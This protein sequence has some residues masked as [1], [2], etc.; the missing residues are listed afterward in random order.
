MSKNN[1]YHESGVDTHKAAKL[2]D[3]MKSDLPRESQGA[4]GKTLGGLGGFAACFQPDFS[5]L[6]EPVIVSCTDGIGTKLLLGL[7][8]NHLKGLG[9]DLVGMCLN[10]LYT[11]GA[12]PLFFLDYFATGVLQQDQFKQVMSGLKDALKQTACPLVG[13]ETAELPGL[14]EKGHFDMAGFVVGVCD[15]ANLRNL[16]LVKENDVLIAL[17][18][19]GFHSNGYS[20]IRKWVKENDE[21]NQP[22]ILEY[23]LSL[24]HI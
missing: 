19:S 18:S 8:S 15:K 9:Q 17:P 10:D 5:S 24:I 20:L 23:L 11:I 3:W 4:F 7:Q 22:E 1:P 12:T 2:V 14:Y 6:E 16:T 21:L 13:G